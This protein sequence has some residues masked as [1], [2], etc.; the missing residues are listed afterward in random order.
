MSLA[1]TDELE[2]INDLGRWDPERD[3]AVI[4]EMK[5]RVPVIG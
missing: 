4:S 2:K 1:S 3:G 5:V